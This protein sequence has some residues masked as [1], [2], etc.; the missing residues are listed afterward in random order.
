VIQLRARRGFVVSHVHIASDQ[1]NWRVYFILGFGIKT[2]VIGPGYDDK[3]R[4][5]LDRYSIAFPVSPKRILGLTDC[6]PFST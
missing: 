3:L 6:Q 2:R 5:L 4:L 1:V